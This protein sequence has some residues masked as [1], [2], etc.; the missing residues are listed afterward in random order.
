MTLSPESPNLIMTKLA[1]GMTKVYI[2]KM[3]NVSLRTVYGIFNDGNASN[4]SSKRLQKKKTS[5]ESIIRAVKA[6]NQDKQRVSC[7]KIAEKIQSQ[8]SNS[9][10]RRNLRSMGYKYLPTT[11]S[12]ILN[13]FQ[14]KLLFQIAIT[15]RIDFHKVVS[16][17][18]IGFTLDSNDNVKT[19]CKTN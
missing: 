10:I 8:L 12:I 16:T 18:E 1:E 14:K 9:T 6:F 7:T 19:W 11:K 15:E 5:K 17:D 13:D 4:P 3:L 2:A